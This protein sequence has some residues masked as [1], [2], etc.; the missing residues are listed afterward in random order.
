MIK[1]LAFGIA[2]TGI[3][4]LL[5][6][7]AANATLYNFYDVLL[8]VNEV[9]ANASTATGTLTG[10]YDDVSKFWE[11]TYDVTFV[12][13]LGTIEDGH[14]HGLA[15]AVG[16]NA[17]ILFDLSLMAAAGVS[18]PDGTFEPTDSLYTFELDMDSALGSALLGVVGVS[19]AQFETALLG[20]DLYLNL[21]TTDIP[22]GEIRANFLLVN[23]V[24]EPASMT[25]LGAGIMGLSYFGKRRKA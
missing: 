11:W 25:L 1:K 13:D 22:T 14:V 9:P 4:A 23:D 12:G 24:P 3:A 7:T 20:E 5:S 19:L 21:H 18:E 17:P 15:G 10:S 8:G 16:F 6:S 2:A